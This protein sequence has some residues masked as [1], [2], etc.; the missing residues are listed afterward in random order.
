MQVVNLSCG[1]G[2]KEA[3]DFIN[4]VFMPHLQEF[5]VAQGED[6][7]VFEASGAWAVST[8]SFVID[9][10]LFKGGDIGKLCVCGS[11]NDITMQG[12][13]PAYLSVGFILEEGLE[14]QTL[15]E[16]LHSMQGQLRLGG[17]K[18]ISLD[19][20]VV[21]KGC[22]DKIF[23]STTALG[24]VLYPNLSAKNLKEGQAIVVSGAIGTHGAMLFALRSE[25]QLDTP[26]ESDCKQLYPLLEPVFE[27]GCKLYALRDATRGGLASVLHEWAQSSTVGIEV[28]EEQI[29]V[30]EGV[31][32]VCEI[33]GLEP[34]VLANEG[35]CVL[36]VESCDAP[37]VC[38]MLQE[39][40]AKAC[41]IGQVVSAL[42]VT[43]KTPWGSKRPL[44]ILEGE[45]LPRIC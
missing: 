23:I 33:L 13:R 32:G 43:L 35:V 7:G 1:N 37:K 22:V 26:L 45:L 3:Q 30:L 9:P 24:P 11:A 18:L 44:D 36:S 40:G 5:L 31:R 19:T 28:S 38:A 12:A 34:F 42:G 16:I 27:S 41:I 20:K 25:I 6:A 29:P 4:K 21:P 15:Q 39:R 14:I 2:G 10:P 8:D 17:L